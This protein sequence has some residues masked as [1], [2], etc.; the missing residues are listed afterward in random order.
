MLFRSLPHHAQHDVPHRVALAQRG[1]IHHLAW[2]P[3][4]HGERLER[5]VTR[6]ILLVLAEFVGKQSDQDVRLHLLQLANRSFQLG[7]HR[8]VRLF[9]GD[10]RGNR[11]LT[12]A[13]RGGAGTTTVRQVDPLFLYVVE[14][15]DGAYLTAYCRL[16]QEFRTFRVDR[17]YYA[18]AA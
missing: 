2:Q 10:I 7:A 12:F 11:P 6:P 13:Y 18:A 17:I 5:V 3:S 14:K 9:L 8:G 4:A 16:R 1:L 15:F